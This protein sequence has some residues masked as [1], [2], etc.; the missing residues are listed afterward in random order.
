MIQ[1]NKCTYRQT[2]QQ[3]LPLGHTF[4]KPTKEPTANC[5]H[6]PNLPLRCHDQPQTPLD[7]I[8]FYAL[9]TFPA[10][11][12]WLV[13]SCVLSGR[14]WWVFLCVNA[15]FGSG[16]VRVCVCESKRV[17]SMWGMFFL[18][19]TYLF[20]NYLLLFFLKSTDQEWQLEFRCVDTLHTL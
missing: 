17:R 8:V 10:I 3:F 14:V 7:N 15:A 20:M 19:F 12:L 2:N 13:Y 16:W 5:G 11:R 9:G 4:T 18:M 1:V 6:P